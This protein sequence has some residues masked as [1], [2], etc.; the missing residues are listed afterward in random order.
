MDVITADSFVSEA[1][2]LLGAPFVH[3]GHT[4]HGVDCMGLL[5][6][7]A[8]RAGIDLIR[9]PVFRD[10]AD[11]ERW[12]Y[13]RRPNARLLKYVASH[14]KKAAKP[15]AGCV[16]FFRFDHETHPQHFAIYTGPTI[17]HAHQPMGRVVEHA[18]RG[19]WVRWTHSMWLLP[20]VEYVRE[21]S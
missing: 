20:G 19:A 15:V 3:Q 6:V 17:I 18:Y 12:N 1:R 21:P 14:C 5:Y 9:L 2:K 11:S 16:A 13:G 7:A 10:L 4:E 8:K